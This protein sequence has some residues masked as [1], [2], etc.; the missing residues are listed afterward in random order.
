MQSALAFSLLSLPLLAAACGGKVVVDAASTSEGAGGATSGAATA[1]V[2]SSFSAVSSA[3][4][5]V[6]A[7]GAGPV[8]CG[9]EAGVTCAGGQVCD[10]ADDHCGG[11]DSAGTCQ[12]L[13]DGCPPDCPGV[14]G[15]DGQFH[16]SACAAH[17]A[18]TDVNVNGSCLGFGAQYAAVF[19]LADLDHLVLRVGYPERNVCLQIFLDAP[20]GINPAFPF[21]APDSWGVS[22]AVISAS[23]DDCTASF[24]NSLTDPQAAKSG[25]GTLS[26]NVAA[27]MSYPCELSFQAKLEFPGAPAWVH[28]VEVAEAK[29]VKVEGGCF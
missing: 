21:M 13:P 28:P 22:G 16:C 5:T 10:F 11:D 25:T 9:G 27:G 1:M 19:F 17:A 18:G 14:C 23:F 29:G 2:S 6:G 15:C 26:W 24:P 4:T 20:S 12:P 8:F 7:G 3:V